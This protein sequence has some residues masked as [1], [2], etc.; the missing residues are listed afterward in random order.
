M[1]TQILRLPEVM[2]RVPLSRSAI[3][4]RI[5]EGTFPAPV[6]LGPRAVGWPDDEVGE[7]VAARYRERDGE[8]G[9]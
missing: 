5:K 8:A 9:Q 2:R 4:K 7:W 3:Y 1:S 6:P